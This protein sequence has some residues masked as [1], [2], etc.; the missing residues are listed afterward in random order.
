MNKRVTDNSVVC[1]KCG[2]TNIIYEGGM[3][4]PARMEEVLY[5]A[6]CNEILGY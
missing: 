3:K 4:Y 6:C 1:P 2:K 5:C